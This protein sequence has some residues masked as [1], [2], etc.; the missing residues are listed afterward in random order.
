MELHIDLASDRTNRRRLQ[1][2]MAQRKFRQAR[3]EAS[4]QHAADTTP[5]LHDA[6]D[7]DSVGIPLSGTQLGFQHEPHISPQATTTQAVYH[8]T[9]SLGQTRS[10]PFAQNAGSSAGSDSPGLGDF[11]L[12]ET[13]FPSGSSSL[14]SYRT[15]FGHSLGFDTSSTSQTSQADVDYL[16]GLASSGFRD[17]PG[18]LHP[19]QHTTARVPK[20]VE[21][22]EATAARAKPDSSGLTGRSSSDGSPTPRSDNPSSSSGSSPSTSGGALAGASP[23]SG[24]NQT[25]VADRGWLGT[26]HIAA[27]RGHERIVRRLMERD[28]DC[29]EKDSDG[30]TALIHASIDGHEAV[31]RILLQAGARI[32][33]LDRRKRSALHWAVLGSHEAVLRLLLEYYTQRNWEHGLDA[34][35]ELGWTSLHIAVEKDFESA[36]LVLLEAGAD[37]H[38]KARKTCEGDNDEGDTRIQANSQ[39]VIKDR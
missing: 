25:P 32:S 7:N 11:T 14:S 2:R 13:Y 28:V 39:D 8:T 16:L 34:Y 21:Q 24:D 36:V 22:P 30:R 35:D 38:A 37:L 31:A 4:N 15:Q 19:A 6:L 33:D 18:Q 17:S 10:A 29:N 1:N 26:L 9:A 3:A 20:V 27:R 12:I 23:S 5:P